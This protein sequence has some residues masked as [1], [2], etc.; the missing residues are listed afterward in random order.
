MPQCQELL[1]VDI[2]NANMYKGL[3]VLR[4]VQY[5]EAH[6]NGFEKKKKKRE[7]RSKEKAKNEKCTEK[8]KL[9]YE[10]WGRTYRPN[11]N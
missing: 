5:P 9:E 8:P 6:N 2:H 11:V 4:G 10:S 3:K 1:Y 7:G